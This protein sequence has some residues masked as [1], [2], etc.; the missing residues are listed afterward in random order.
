MHKVGKCKKL[1][2][3]SPMKTAI[4]FFSF[5]LVATVVSAQS[6]PAQPTSGPGGS[7]YTHALTQMNEYGSA[8]EQFW[9]FEPVDPKPDSADVI[10]F[11]HG[12]ADVNPQVYGG[13]INHLVR[14]G[15][16]VIFPRYQMGDIGESDTAFSSFAGLAIKAAFDTLTHPNHVIPRL[17]HFAIAGHSYGGLMTANMGII[18]D[19]FGF[20]A[21]KCLFVAEAYNDAANTVRI[22]NYNIMP[23]D[24]KMQI[25][26]G[27]NDAI[28]GN[29]FGRFLMDST[30]NVNTSHKNYIKLKPDNHGSPAIAAD[31]SDPMSKLDAFDSGVT[32]ALIIGSLFTL[33]T[34]AA[35]YFCFWKLFDALLSC[36][37]YNQDCEYAFG[38][39]PQQKNMG[40]WSDGTPLTPLE[41]EPASTSVSEQELAVVKLFPNPAIEKVYFSGQPTHIS[42]TDITGRTLYSGNAI[43]DG[44]AVDRW[45]SGLYLYKLEM[46]NG[47]RATG[48]LWVKA[49]N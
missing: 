41:V 1:F 20:P 11:I 7:D 19:D 44:I 23:A 35:D 10:A 21:P 25:V 16:I 31:H 37:F 28:V 36:T 27:Q 3:L 8:E 30:I 48:K 24:M 42:I 38:D 49:G 9:I 6:Q 14:K 15:N 43:A 39:T 40:S 29:T 22:P 32:N 5:W 13:W 46:Q 34:D 47:E 4:P 18:N 45:P 12:L 17:N 2:Y 33:A 26:V